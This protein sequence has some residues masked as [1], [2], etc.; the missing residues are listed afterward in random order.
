MAFAGF[1]GTVG[2]ALALS[3]YVNLL[4]HMEE[5]ELKACKC[6]R[7]V[8]CFAGGI[9]FFTLLLIGIASKPVLEGLGLAAE[10]KT[11]HEVVQNYQEQLKKRALRNYVRLLSE[12]RFK[13]VDHSAVMGFVPALRNITLEDLLQAARCQKSNTAGHLYHQPAL[14]HVLPYL[15]EGTGGGRDDSLLQSIALRH[16]RIFRGV[17]K[18]EFTRIFD[19]SF[20]GS[21]HAGEDQEAINE[22]RLT[23]IELLREAYHKQI[24]DNELL[25]NSNIAHSLFESLNFCENLVNKG[26]ELNDWEGVGVASATRVVVVNRAFYIILL[27]L[28]HIWQGKVKWTSRLRF[29]FERFEKWFLVRQALA[30]VKAHRCAQQEFKENFAANPVTKEQQRILNES[31]TQILA[32]EG[33]LEQVDRDDVERIKSHFFCQILISESKQ[34]VMTLHGQGLIPEKDANA[35]LEELDDH[36][37]EVVMW[38][39]MAY[40]GHLGLDEQAE[41]LRN[42]PQNLIEEF[43]L[44]EAIEDMTNAGGR[45]TRLA[46]S[47]TIGLVDNEFDD[48]TVRASYYRSTLS[49]ST[50]DDLTQPLLGEESDSN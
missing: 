39:R 23:F 38:H 50:A 45:P 4:E 46:R 26:H 18:R 27:R 11:R 21:E 3:L 44:E 24:T 42:L 41:R 10:E 16:V 48:S 36:L 9:A 6:A 33:D 40:G 19:D 15:V 43:N 32:V 34:Y 12:P 7:E 30:F 13:G 2:I 29:N 5:T 8:Y 25:E 14:E 22:Y 47:T 35:M 28:K 1:R 20:F 49:S 31:A 17:E 37:E